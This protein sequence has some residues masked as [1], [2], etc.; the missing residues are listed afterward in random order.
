MLQVILFVLTEK[1]MSY[2]IVGPWFY[3]NAGRN[4]LWFV[5]YSLFKN[6]PFNRKKPC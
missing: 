6:A 4:M 3:D 1:R 2:K 5:L